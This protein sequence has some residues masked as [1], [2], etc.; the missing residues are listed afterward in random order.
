MRGQLASSLTLALLLEPLL[1]HKTLVL[2]L[3]L[4]GLGRSLKLLSSRLCSH[5]CLLLL[6]FLEITG[7]CLA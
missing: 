6:L 5:L 4:E 3:L 1:L 2:L 7:T